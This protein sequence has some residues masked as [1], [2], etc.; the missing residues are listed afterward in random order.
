M[1]RRQKSR[2]RVLIRP[3]AVEFVSSRAH[4]EAHATSPAHGSVA[5]S[6]ANVS[7][8]CAP[9]HRWIHCYADIE[10]EI[11]LSRHVSLVHVD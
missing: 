2:D 5:Q 7:V 9:C 3:P 11:A 8:F 4:L 1:E 10:P 6:E